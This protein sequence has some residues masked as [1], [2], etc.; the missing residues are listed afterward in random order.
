MESKDR[1]ETISTTEF[2]PL[3]RMNWE[4]LGSAKFVEVSYLIKPFSN[5]QSIRFTGD[6]LMKLPIQFLS[7]FL[8]SFLDYR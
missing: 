6:Q 4:L 7:F 1:P 5:L 3:E 2:A 8:L